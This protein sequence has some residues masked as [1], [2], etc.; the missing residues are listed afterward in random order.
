MI[1][2][3]WALSAQARYYLRR[4][5]PT[6]IALDAIR[7]R[8]GLK[9]GIP[10]MLLAAPYLAATKLLT[11]HIEQGGPDW[12]HLVV[13]LCAWNALKMLWLGPLGIAWLLRAR[14]AERGV[15]VRAFSEG[16]RITVTTEEETD[17]LLQAWNATIGG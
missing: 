14:L 8:R 15:L 17:T 7:T 6:N 13:L 2:L 11:D 1:R 4:Y 5:M 12:F 10:A 16:I 3:L 9:W